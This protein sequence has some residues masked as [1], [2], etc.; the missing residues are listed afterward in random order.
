MIRRV[1]RR[2]LKSKPGHKSVRKSRYYTLRYKL[3]WM[4][5]VEEVS[6]RLTD[7]QSAEAK[8]NEIIRQ[9]EQ[10]HYGIIDSAS[11]RHAAQAELVIH[12]TDYVNDLNARGKAGR[13]GSWGREVTSRVNRLIK[14]CSWKYPR[15]I[16]P[17]SFEKWRARVDMSPK[18]KN[19]YL[20]TANTVL[21]WMIRV[22]RIASNPLVSVQKVRVAGMEKRKRRA[23]SEPELKRLIDVSESRG[24]V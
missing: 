12:L 17:D 9:K 5:T 1:Y 2:K 15:Q 6:L 14:K 4:N 18:T 24:T 21:N 16:T 7:K 8:A 20:D 3:D 23:L 22:G 13:N 10:E 11:I 19:H